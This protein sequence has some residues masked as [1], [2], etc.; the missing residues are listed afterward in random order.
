MLSD[1]W[2]GESRAFDRNV[3]LDFGM[4]LWWVYLSN[5]SDGHA[6]GVQRWK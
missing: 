3:E 5:G 6:D 2:Q 1:T 4:A